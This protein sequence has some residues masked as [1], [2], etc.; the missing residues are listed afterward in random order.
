MKVHAPIFIPSPANAA[1]LSPAAK[2]AAQRAADD[3]QPSFQTAL[4]TKQDSGSSA[5]AGDRSPTGRGAAAPPR[6]AATAAPAPAASAPAALP[7]ELV[8]RAGDAP[9]APGALINITA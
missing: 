4:G 7:T 3:T 5:Q 8:A 9:Y 1:A 2:D 6:R